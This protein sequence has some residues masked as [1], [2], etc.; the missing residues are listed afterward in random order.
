LV[1]TSVPLVA[2]ASAFVPLKYHWSVGVGQRDAGGYTIVAA[3]AG[4]SVTSTV[5]TLTV[6]VPPTISVQPASQT[7]SAL[8]NA[9]FGVTATGTAPLAY[10]WH[11]NG[12]AVAGATN[13][14]FTVSNLTTAAAGNYFVVVTNVA[15]AATSSVAALTVERLVPAVTWTNPAAI[16][17]GTALGGTQLNA[18]TPVAGTFA[19]SPTSGTILPAGTHGLTNEFTPTDATAYVGTTGTVSVV[20]NPAALTVTA[21]SQTRAFGTANGPLTVGYAGFVNSE[22]TNVL[23]SVAVAATAADINSLPGSYPITVSGAAGANYSVTHVAGLLVVTAVPPALVV[24]ATNQTVVAG[25]DVTHMAVATGAPTP[26]LQW[27]FNGTNALAGAT[28]GTLVVTNAQPANAGGYTIVAANAGGS[29]TSAVATLTVLVP[30]TISVQPAS[31]MVLAGSNV[32]FSVGATG[33]LPL[34]HQ[35]LFNGGPLAN[36]TNAMLVV[37]NAQ[38]AVAGAYSVTVSNAAGVAAS[39]NAVLSLGALPDI[40]IQPVGQTS[41]IGASLTFFV[42]ATGTPAPTYQWHRNAV[43]ISGATGSSLSFGSLQATNAGTYSVVVAN[44]FGTLTSSNAV[45]QLTAAAAPVIVTQ[46]QSQ[47][48]LEGATVTFTVGASGTPA[49]TYQWVK[50]SSAI[51]GATGASLTLTNLT[52]ASAGSYVVQVFNS[53]G[54]TSSVP[55]TLQILVPPAITAQPVAVVTNLGADAAFTVT[56]TGLPAPVHQWF[57]DGLAI[58][59]P[60]A[61]FLGQ[62][63]SNLSVLAV[64][65]GQ[66]GTYFVVVTNV[67]GAVTSAPVTLSLTPAPLITVHPA[68]ALVIRTNL[69]PSAPVVFSVTATGAPPLGYQW[70]FNGTGLPDATNATLTWTNFARS[71]AGLFS[72]LVSNPGGSVLSSNAL[73]EIRVAQIVGVPVRLPGGAVRVSFGDMDGLGVVAS[74]VSRFEVQFTTNFVDWVATPFGLSM[75]NGKFILDDPGQ[76]ASPRRFYRVIER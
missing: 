27:Y 10:Q 74:N 68:G 12:V 40:V 37:S 23:A 59:S 53:A 46:P 66:A 30:P 52:L 35:W 22:T 1:T 34:H 14:G 11:S 63:T 50:D 25:V 60:T 4:G 41:I 43:P 62:T 9:V 26:V 67:A 5:A 24:E 75:L 19:Y 32:T 21:G 49:P 69:G 61:G 28:N 58:A 48:A 6:L 17:Y 70:R 3:N 47:A 18:S 16:T 39:S 7:N 20:V 57:K 73:L 2:P 71:N 29:V 51:P 55:A 64:Q 76:A 31:Q 54:S 8:A 36:E 38:P 42:T 33:T 72:V 56:A 45:L 13:A 65:P 15:G 44:A